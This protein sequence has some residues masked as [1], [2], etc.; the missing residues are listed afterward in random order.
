MRRAVR[1]AVWAGLMALG[2]WTALPVGPVP[3]TLQTFF[4]LLAGFVE[5]PSAAVAA[6]IY[7]A[8][9]L[10]GLPVFAGGVAGPAL[11]FGPTAGYALSYPLAAALAGVSKR[12]PFGPDW[13]RLLVCGLAASILILLCGSV[14]LMIVRGF[15]PAAAL[16]FNAVFLPGDAL[17]TAA[18][19]AA[20]VGLK[21]RRS[22][23]VG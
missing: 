16:T 17:K 21:R 1:L 9:G 14:G 15:E 8:A 12:V 20:A 3:I 23:R 2:A 6:L 19:V 11:L 22:G 10:L 13:L 7:L 18:A 4:I 5:G